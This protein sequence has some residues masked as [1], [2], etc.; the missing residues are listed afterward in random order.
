MDK[1]RGISD[2][3][4][5]TKI[6]EGEEKG[7]YRLKVMLS[8][9]KAHE[10]AHGIIGEEKQS[11]VH[12]AFNLDGEPEALRAFIDELKKLNPEQQVETYNAGLVAKRQKEMT[13]AQQANLTV[14]AK[15]VYQELSE[16]A[17]EALEKKC[18]KDVTQQSPIIKDLPLSRPIAAQRSSPGTIGIR[19]PDKTDG[20]RERD[21][22]RSNKLILSD[23]L[24]NIKA[25]IL[26]KRDFG[27]WPI[28]L[29]CHP[30]KHYVPEHIRNF[31]KEFNNNT[32]LFNTNM[33]NIP[34]HTMQSGEYFDYLR[35]AVE[36]AAAKPMQYQQQPDASRVLAAATLH[37]FKEQTVLTENYYM[38]NKGDKA[39]ASKLG[40]LKEHI[41]NYL[42]EQ[43]PNEISALKK[44]V[45][46]RQ[47][48]AGQSHYR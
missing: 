21:N 22:G 29:I 46:E 26:V 35:K 11:L 1:L 30:K 8:G 25:E 16:K 34:V 15:D 20:S 37:L 24:D 14:A 48:D 44:V 6:V 23:A 31:V 12:E 27:T 4:I 36:E 40:A 43:Y 33:I 45:E 3:K 32:R 42:N 2:L 17:Q 9:R 19:A 41:D 18:K 47:E 10:I 5:K 28:L 13:E 38:T 39:V 7:T